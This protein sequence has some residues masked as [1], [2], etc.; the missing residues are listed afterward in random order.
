MCLSW[1]MGVTLAVSAWLVAAPAEAANAQQGQA[2]NARRA[3]V[4]AKQESMRVATRASAASAKNGARNIHRSKVRSIRRGG[5]QCVPFARTASGIDVRGNA[6]LWW[7]QAAG[8]YARGQTPEAGSV[9][10]FRSNR[11]MPLG[12]VAV[13][14]RVINSREV[15]IDHAN[16]AGPG[17]RKGRISR[18]VSVVDVSDSND[19]TA[20]RVELGNSE[21]YGSIYP[22]NGF[23][24][25]RPESGAIMLA[26]A[27]Q[28][29]SL[30]DLN[31]A[32]RDLRGA[33]SRGGSGYASVS[34]AGGRYEE[35]AEAPVEPRRSTVR[36]ARRARH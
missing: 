8:V 10:S 25:D 5:L 7:D 19:W 30:P 32:P 34:Y 22:T 3:H 27:P 1:L 21:N 33:G 35:V 6:H 4:A 12:H 20:V 29:A 17:G 26:V 23:I 11:S 16:W 24:Y 31:T 18:G 15:E 13:V 2:T 14:S 28:A 9:L 36:K